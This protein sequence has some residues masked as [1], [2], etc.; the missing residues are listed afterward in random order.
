MAEKLNI[1]DHH[2]AHVLAVAVSDDGNYLVS[3]GRDKKILVWDI[4]SQTIINTLKSHKD[5]VSV[6]CTSFSSL[7]KRGV[8]RNSLTHLLTLN[9]FT[10][11]GVS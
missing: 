11:A 10:G 2:T 1:E 4:R 3:G 5:A 9:W 6:S 8:K 7:M